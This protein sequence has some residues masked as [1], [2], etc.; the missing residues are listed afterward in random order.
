MIGWASIQ[1][2]VMRCAR[3]Y[4]MAMMTSASSKR[5][6]DI[7]ADKAAMCIN[8]VLKASWLEM[9]IHW[10]ALAGDIDAEATTTRLMQSARSRNDR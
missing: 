9:D 3:C 7:C 6:A 1:L 2:S 8:P 10:R 5:K 4:K